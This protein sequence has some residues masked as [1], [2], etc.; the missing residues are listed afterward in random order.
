MRSLSN[1][2]QSAAEIL[3]MV[4]IDLFPGTLFVG[5]YANEFGFYADFVS[6]QPID[7]QALGFIDTRMRGLIKENKEVRHHNMMRENAAALLDHRQQPFRADNALDA[8]ENIVTMIQIDQFQDYCS[9]IPISNTQEIAAFKLLKVEQVTKTF[10]EQDEIQV[11]RIH[12]TVFPNPQNLKKYLK[13]YEAGK[14]RDHRIL[15]KEMELCTQL[16]QMNTSVWAWFSK[17]V[18]LRELLKGL[19]CQE[20]KTQGFQFLISPVL[21]NKAL[22]DKLRFKTDTFP[23][24]AVNING[25][26]HIMLTDLGP[27]HAQIYLQKEKKY[28]DLPIRYAECA[29]LPS[30]RKSGDLWGMFDAEIA[31]IDQAHIFCTLEQVEEEIISSLQFIDKIIKIFSFEC[32]WSLKGRG[33]KFAGTPKGWKRG[34]DALA[35]AFEKCGIAFEQDSDEIAYE[36][37]T[38]EMTL[39]D[40]LGRE[41]AGPRVSIDLNVPES[42]NL[43]YEGTDGARHQAVMIK[44]SLF[45]SIE[46]FIAILVEHYAGRFPLWLAPEQVRLLVV[47]EH[48]R[49][50]GERL[51][52]EIE[53]AGI[54]ATLD[55]RPGPL[56][57]RIHEAERERVP[58]LIVVGEREEKKQL[59]TVRSG[60]YEK[61]Q[62]EVT[63]EAFLNEIRQEVTR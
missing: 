59:I 8:P 26:E 22:L 6:N 31:T 30:A 24:T 27:A 57:A 48:V 47:G 23:S 56:G 25:L 63:I 51:F 16:D 55:Q 42:Y 11:I 7:D 4:V 29:S 41:W 12:G 2:R 53:N 14:K 40:S 38:A 9:F 54:R 5:G 61:G 19:W 10:S 21:V 37:P 33:Q 49:P 44:R 45:G 1:L 62:S 15:C 28:N 50:Y 39:V 46:R 58:Y 17:G 36:G 18:T 35:S 20:L 60:S 32:H 52:Q 34:I 43:R 3:A 13:G